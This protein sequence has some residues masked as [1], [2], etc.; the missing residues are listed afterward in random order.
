MEPTNVTTK[1]IE[2]LP[3]NI[4]GVISNPNIESRIREISTKYSLNAEQGESLIDIVMLVLAGIENPDT[5]IEN[6]MSDLS[7]SE[8]VAEQIIND[9]DGRVFEYAIKEA[10]DIGG[11][12]KNNKTK[13][14]ADNLPEIRPENLPLVEQSKPESTVS[15]PVPNYTPKAKVFAPEPTQTPISVPRFKAIPLEE[16]EIGENFIPNIA[17]K[18]SG[19]GIMENKLNSVM[20]S[21]GDSETQTSAP[22]K[23]TV[24]PYREPLS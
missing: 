22:K 3:D 10:G 6:I 12:L 17:P 18:P 9:L 4:K 8:I 15:A 19:Q 20:K 13:E 2:S 5:L 14:V 24:D 21:T 1:Y 11:G 7:V 23:Y 16:G